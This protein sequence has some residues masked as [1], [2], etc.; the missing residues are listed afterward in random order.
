M[1][2]S[3]NK[4]DSDDAE[5][6]DKKIEQIDFLLKS[7]DGR[8]YIKDNF[9]DIKKLLL[10]ESRE[11]NLCSFFEFV[12]NLKL[13]SEFEEEYEE[14]SF[15]GNLYKEIE[16]PKYD[17]KSAGYSITDIFKMRDTELRKLRALK[18]GKIMKDVVFRNIILSQDQI[19]RPEKQIILQEISKGEKYKFISAGTSS[20][21]L[22]TRDQVVKLGF[23][24][25]FE[26]PYH[27]RIMMPYFRKKYND[28]S[29]LEI[30]NYANVESTDIT[31]EKV[32]EIYKELEKDGIIWGD[33]SKRN[34]VVLQKDN[35]LPDYIT[36]DEFNVL[37]FLEDC[38]FPTNNHIALKKGDIVICDLDMLYSKDDPFISYGDIDDIIESYIARQ[39]RESRNKTR[40]E[41]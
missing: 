17:L 29:C 13:F 4:L 40:E 21:I 32:L 3:M 11:R 5:Y 31:D 26:I 9:E 36:S 41:K 16:I 25:K 20:L 39:M 28:D 35:N 10:E 18:D 34:L 33:A 22:Q 23:R 14:Y 27:P 12:E 37:G 38:N 8:K 15:W 7:E 19:S 2:Y 6:L 30:F 24:R 1:L